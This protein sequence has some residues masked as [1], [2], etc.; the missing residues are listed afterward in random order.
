MRPESINEQIEIIAYFT[1]GK[2]KP[3]RIRWK[4]KVYRVREVCSLWTEDHGQEQKTH[5]TVQVTTDD[6]MEL[7]YDNA[8]F[9]WKL[10]RVYLAG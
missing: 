9:K 6:Y 2:L 1:S 4:N 5:V 8:T 3:L 7:L 10:I